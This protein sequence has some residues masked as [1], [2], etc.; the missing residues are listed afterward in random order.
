MADSDTLNPYDNQPSYGT[1]TLGP[2]KVP[3]IITAI[4]GADRKWTYDKQRPVGKSGAVNVYKGSEPCD[5][6]KVD[7]ALTTAAH[8]VALRSFR[9][10]V[11]PPAVG[12]PTAFDVS[13]AVLQNAGVKSVAIKSFGQETYAGNGLWTVSLE[14]VE[15]F[16]P[17][18]TST[19][20]ADK[21]KWVLT[22]GDAPSAADALVNEYLEKAKNP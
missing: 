1:M 6:I 7:I 16:P 20:P 8:F 22:Q 15:F 14:L 13:N 5:S 11:T 19:G 17:R 10:A 2:H 18:A 9:A 3:G 12:R 21:S 4:T